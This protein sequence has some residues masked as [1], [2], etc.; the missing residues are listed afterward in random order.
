[1]VCS[2]CAHYSSLSDPLALLPSPCS[3]VPR[4]CLVRLLDDDDDPHGDPRL[5]SEFASF[6]VSTSTSCEHS[7]VIRGWHCGARKTKSNLFPK[8]ATDQ[9]VGWRTSGQTRSPPVSSV[10]DPAFPLL[11]SR[12]ENGL[13]FFQWLAVLH[14][15]TWFFQSIILPL[16]FF[17]SNP[18]T[19]SR[20][21]VCGRDC[22]LWISL[23]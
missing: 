15:I 23:Q 17:S 7:H 16:R 2:S 18:E 6:F 9:S 19:I 12:F 13:S 1:M 14:W 11:L 10:A 8:L 21:R 3:L 5:T 22:L 20:G 4:S